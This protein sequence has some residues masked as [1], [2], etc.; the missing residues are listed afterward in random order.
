MDKFVEAPIHQTFEQLSIA[1]AEKGHMR[2]LARAIEKC[3]W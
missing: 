3:P 1:Q 2:T